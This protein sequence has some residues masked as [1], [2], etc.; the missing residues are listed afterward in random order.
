M[1]CGLPGRVEP[2]QEGNNNTEGSSCTVSV[3]GFFQVW[4]MQSINDIFYTPQVE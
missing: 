3:T 4:V 1:L 2:Y